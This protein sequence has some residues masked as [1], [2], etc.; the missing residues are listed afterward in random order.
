MNVPK[1]RAINIISV[2]GKK[3]DTNL[4]KQLEGLTR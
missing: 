3:T 4:E 2:L 1:S